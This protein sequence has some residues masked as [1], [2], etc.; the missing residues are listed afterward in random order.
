MNPIY[1][2]GEQTV[3]FSDLDITKNIAGALRVA[4]L[5]RLFAGKTLYEDDPIL[6]D[7]KG[8]GTG[9]WTNNKFEMSVTSGQYFIRQ[10][11]RPIPYFEGSPI[12]GEFTFEN[13]HAEADVVKSVGLY[14][15]TTVA[16][17]ATVYD[18]YRV[19]NDGTTLRIITSRAGTE[20]FNVPYASW[21]NYK[22]LDAVNWHLNLDLF[23]AAF[24]EKLWLGGVAYRLW[25]ATGY[26]WV[27]AHTVTQIDAAGYI[28]LSPNQ[29]VR[30]EI[31]STTGSGSFTA[32]CS[33]VSSEGGDIELGKPVIIENTAL[34]STN[35]VGTVYALMGVKKRTDRPLKCVFFHRMDVINTSSSNAG[36]LLLL[37]NPT[38]SS[39]ITYANKT[40][41]AVQ[42]GLATAQ[43]VTAL[44]TIIEGVGSRSQGTQGNMA[45]NLYAALSQ[46]I[47]NTMDEYVLAFRPT[48]ATQSMTAIL[49][50]REF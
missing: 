50:M 20:T 5:S 44:G 19:V 33:Q 39:A 36:H 22:F 6:W 8:T 23:H 34:I 45:D 18:G 32:N 27:I 2:N 26:G 3:K 38:L 4:H 16:P 29:F 15:S 21:D 25:V 49:T 10:S 13:F 31:R 12:V 30:Y 48:T 46:Q 24:V 41:T 42:F 17:Y 43:T 9:T 37:H 14:S 47:D 40:D 7:T 11:R 28:E 35:S 1:G